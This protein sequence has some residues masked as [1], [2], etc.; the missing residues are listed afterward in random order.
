MSLKIHFLHSHLDF[1]PPKLGAVS[2]E[3]G[4]SFH[5]DSS[6][7]QKRY[8]VKSSQNILAIVVTVLKRCLLP[9]TK[10]LQKK[11]LSVS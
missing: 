4:E 5:Q 9:V 7:M 8:A 2:D 11:F 3:Y 1:F 6:A 10:E